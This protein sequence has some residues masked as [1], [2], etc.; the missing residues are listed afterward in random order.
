[1]SR[2]VAKACRTNSIGRALDTGAE[3]RSVAAARSTGLRLLHFSNPEC[4]GIVSPEG[5]I[6][7]AGP[8]RTF[9]VR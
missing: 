7:S 1:M 4:F 9:T 5:L 2:N 6:G 3:L 8:G